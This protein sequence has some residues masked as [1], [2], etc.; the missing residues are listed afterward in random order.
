V[1]TA[2]SSSKKEHRK[3][4]FVV[5]LLSIVVPKPQNQHTICNVLSVPLISIWIFDLFFVSS[6]TH[7]HV[8]FSLILRVLLHLIAQSMDT[9]P[10]CFVSYRASSYCSSSLSSNS[11]MSSRNLSSFAGGGEE[12]SDRHPNSGAASVVTANTPASVD[13][14]AAGDPFR[15]PTKVLDMKT[16]WDF[17]KI[18]R[19][20]GPGAFEDRRWHCGW[21]G[22]VLKGWNAT[23]AMNHVTKASGNNDVKACTGNIPKETLSAF[24]AFRHKKMGIATVK[25][26]HGAAFAE[27]I[28]ENQ[29]SLSVML[30]DTRKR[31]SRSSGAGNPIDVD[32]ID[33]EGVGGTNATKLTTSIADFVYSKGLPFSACEGEHFLQILK[34]ARLVSSSYRPPTRKS[35]SN[36]LL[37]ISYDN[38]LSKYS[39]DLEVDAEV[40]GLSLF[41]DGATIHGMP[42]MNILAAGVREPCAVLAIVDCKPFLQVCIYIFVPCLT[43]LVSHI[44]TQVLAIWWRVARRALLLLLRCLSRGS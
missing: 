7:P 20:G 22:L 8:F 3:S 33:G 13:K 4:C 44:H 1:L 12:S 15:N 39:N 6:H 30:E 17:E 34:L 29:Q 23:K 19:R 21:C 5:E 14:S 16:V 26:Q 38:R 24:R 43:R 27:A 10:V 41:G 32:N 35:L 37:Q 18:E 2:D 9:F 25:R 42:L 28:A 36:E 40:Y 31:Q 11:T